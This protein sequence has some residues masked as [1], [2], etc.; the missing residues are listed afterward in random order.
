MTDKEL[1]A[2]RRENTIAELEKQ[3][4]LAQHRALRVY[5]PE[6]EDYPSV[7]E[8]VVIRMRR[9]PGVWKGGC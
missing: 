9:A 1:A 8:P 5:D 3:M 2:A 7:P 6:L 4:R